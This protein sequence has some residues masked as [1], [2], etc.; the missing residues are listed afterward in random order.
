[1]Y[2]HNPFR[3]NAIQKKE[4]GAGIYKKKKERKKLEFLKESYKF[5]D[6]K[7]KNEY[8]F[9]DGVQKEESVIKGSQRLRILNKG[10]VLSGDLRTV[11]KKTK[12]F[13]G[14]AIFKIKK[15]FKI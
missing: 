10:S 15:S 1:M 5:S 8:L 11:D 3:K 6:L 14:A 2:L 9:T 13:L 4:L 12:E 7:N